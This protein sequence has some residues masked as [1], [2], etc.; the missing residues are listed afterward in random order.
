MLL[1]LQFLR[2]ILVII[3]EAGFQT[4]AIFMQSGSSERLKAGAVSNRGDDSVREVSITAI[5]DF[6]EDSSHKVCK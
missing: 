1:L 3:H 5:S 6:V 2:Y 4:V